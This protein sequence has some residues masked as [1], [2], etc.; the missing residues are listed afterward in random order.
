VVG[1]DDAHRVLPLR[2]QGGAPPIFEACGLTDREKT[3][4]ILALR[5]HKGSLAEFSHG[6]GG[7]RKFTKRLLQEGQR[8]SHR[9][10]D[11]AVT[12]GRTVVTFISP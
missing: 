8:S 7:Q 11:C 5:G 4:I 6:L 2:A 12:E 3:H 10:Q 1:A 9:L